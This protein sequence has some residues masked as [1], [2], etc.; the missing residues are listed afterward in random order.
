MKVGDMI[1]VTKNS[2]SLRKGDVGII[3]REEHVPP[4]NKKK[5]G[6]VFNYNSKGT[7]P[8]VKTVLPIDIELI[9]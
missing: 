1:R 6:V 7:Y 5:F 2:Y 8:P 3:V 4:T 9:G